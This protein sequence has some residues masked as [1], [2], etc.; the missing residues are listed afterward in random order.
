M[1]NDK[2]EW[3]HY[4]WFEASCNHH[5]IVEGDTIINNIN[6]K[7]IINYGDIC[8]YPYYTF[9]REDTIKKQVFYYYSDTTEIMIYDFSLT[10]GDTIKSVFQ[11]YQFNMVIDSIIT[12]LPEY[13]PCSLPPEIYIETPKIFYLSHINC[14]D[15]KQVIWVEGI[16]NISNPFYCYIPWTAGGLGDA[17]ICHFD[18]KGF[19]DYHYVYCE[20]PEPCKGPIVA[21]EELENEIQLQFYPNPIHETTFLEIIDIKKNI[22]SI[23]LYNS[24]GML[25]IKKNEIFSQ[26]INLS[27]FNPGLIY[28][29]LRTKKGEVIIRKLIKI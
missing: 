14:P 10:V 22:I 27:E 2:S 13:S 18:E 5:L 1:L 24:A 4:F 21:T 7:K 6:Y 17:L 19:Q 26:N 12:K 20:E 8:N 3:H 9:A 25:M 23:D 16:G 11:Y 15:C 28:V 29:V